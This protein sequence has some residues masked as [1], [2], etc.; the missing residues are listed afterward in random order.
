MVL[1][2]VTPFLMLEPFTRQYPF[3]RSEYN[4]YEHKDNE[5]ILGIEKIFLPY[6]NTNGKSHKF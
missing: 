4:N 2:Y 6:R 5:I 3:F 1:P